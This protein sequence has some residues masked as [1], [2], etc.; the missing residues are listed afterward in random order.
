VNKAAAKVICDAGPII[1]LDELDALH[2]L[3]DFQ[4]VI[5]GPLVRQEVAGIRPAA[6]TILESLSISPAVV[7]T[8]DE[9]LLSLCRAFTLDSGE[10][11]ALQLM[12]QFADSIL[13]TDDAAARLVAERMGFEVHGSVGILIR[14][15]R[16]GQMQPAEVLHL[17][18]EIETKSTLFI[19]K[20]LIDYVA[21]SIRK[22]YGL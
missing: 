13:L 20:S 3:G 19:K 22:E 10:I 21:S 15:I 8:H 2:L 1:H 7:P 9:V 16:R 5:V 14:A 17:L 12:K 11:E 4:E 18:G 6:L